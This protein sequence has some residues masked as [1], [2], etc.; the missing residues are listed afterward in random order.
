MTVHVITT[1]RANC[2]RLYGWLERQSDRLLQTITAS[3]ETKTAP[4]VKAQGTG[5]PQFDCPTAVSQ[6]ID[7][8]NIKYTIVA[9]SSDFC[10][11]TLLTFY[12]QHEV[13]PLRQSIS[14][15]TMAHVINSDMHKSMALFSM[16]TN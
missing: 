7:V 6:N 15:V 9:M 2:S 10:K 11:R 16:V 5:G 14:I 4:N 1:F 3:K 12:M 8:D 13:E